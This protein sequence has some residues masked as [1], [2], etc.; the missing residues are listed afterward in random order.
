MSGW[1][2]SDSPKP[3][4][5]A[6][7]GLAIGVETGVRRREGRP[8]RLRREARPGLDRRLTHHPVSNQRRRRSPIEVAGAVCLW[9]LGH[10]DVELHLCEVRRHHEPRL[11]DGLDLVGSDARSDFA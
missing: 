1:G 10:V 9:L 4:I 3:F 7:N 8:G 6:V 11:G 2:Y 5:A